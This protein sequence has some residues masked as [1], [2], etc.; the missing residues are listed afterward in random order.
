MDPATQRVRKLDDVLRT[1]PY[2]YQN[3]QRVRQDV[4]QLLQTCAT[5]QPQVQTFS[6]GGKSVTLFFLNGVIPIKYGGASYNIPVT[7]YFDP[8][9]PAQAPRCFVTPTKDM[10]IMANHPHVDASGMVYLP[11]LSN[12]SHHGY[13]NLPSLV[14]TLASVFSEKPPVVANTSSA[15]AQPPA[16]GGYAAATARPAA[17]VAATVVATPV[18]R[19]SVA[20]VSAGPSAQEQGVKTVTASARQRWH[21]VMKPYSDEVNKQLKEEAELKAEADKAEVELRELQAAAE[22]HKQHE[23][24]LAALQV[25][26]QAFIEANA[27]KEPDPDKLRESLDADNRQVLDCLSEELALE[28]M[29][30]ALDDLLAGRKIGIDDFMREVRDVSRRKFMCSVQ[31]QKAAAAVATAAGV[32]SETSGSTPVSEAL[33]AARGRVMVA[34]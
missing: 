31:R 3:P 8:P 20:A 24:E 19:P 9:Y 5:L 29:L 12:W 33:P 16:A 2:A 6:S 11:Y 32:M 34:A 22:R 26:L 13:S 27:G 14:E 17:T 15:A 18:S 28:E 23:A 1:V 7:V 4:A 10:S 30:I 21:T 25:G